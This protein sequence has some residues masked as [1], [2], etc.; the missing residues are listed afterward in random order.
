MLI[1]QK[2]SEICQSG[3]CNTPFFVDKWHGLSQDIDKINK[4]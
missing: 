1:R 3:F 4:K 2:I